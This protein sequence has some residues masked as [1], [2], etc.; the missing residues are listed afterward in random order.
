MHP[1]PGEIVA[2]IVDIQE[3]QGLGQGQPGMQ[4]FGDP[5]APGMNADHGGT[6]DVAAGDLRSQ[7]RLEAV[8]QHADVHGGFKHSGFPLG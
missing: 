7:C 1:D 3:A 6:G 5:G 2:V 4:P 8:E